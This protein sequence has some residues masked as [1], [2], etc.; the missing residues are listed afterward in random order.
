M[1]ASPSWNVF[2]VDFG[3]AFT[4]ALGVTGDLRLR[5]DPQHADRRRRRCRLGTRGPAR[6]GRGAVPRL[7]ALAVAGARCAGPVGRP[8]RVDG[9]GAGVRA[10]RAGRVGAPARRLAGLRGALRAGRRTVPRRRG[11]ELRGSR[12]AGRA[13]ARRVR[14][15]PVRDLARARGPAA[16]RGPHG[17]GPHPARAGGGAARVRRVVLAGPVRRWRGQRRA[18]AP[19]ARRC[20]GPSVLRRR[21]AARADRRRGLRGR[22]GRRRAAGAAGDP[23][24]VGAL[25]AAPAARQLGRGVRLLGPGEPGGGR[26]AVRRHGR[27]PARRERRAQVHRRERE[28]LPR[29]GGVPR[30]GARRHRPRSSRCRPR[31]RWTPRRCPRRSAPRWRCTRRRARRWT[32]WSRRT[33]PASSSAPEVVEATL[34]VRRY[35][36]KTYGDA[37]PADVAEVCRLAFSC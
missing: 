32:R 5:I 20:R 33:W 22:R 21:R 10:R 13:V 29:R 18:P 30:A 14:G 12:R 3:I 34:A 23:R 11:G 8:A 9:P 7:P 27:Q 25:A 26:A 35:E 28:P 19:V 37:E 6:A 15:R 31:C 2:C 24:R 36:Q 17:A 1:G 4:P 16:H